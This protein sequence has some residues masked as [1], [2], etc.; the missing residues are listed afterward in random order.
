[1]SLKPLVQ[2]FKEYLQQLNT[3]WLAQCLGMN[4]YNQTQ[5]INRVIRDYL[6]CGEIPYWVLG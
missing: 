4:D 5:D 1:M 3:K 2:F 6:G